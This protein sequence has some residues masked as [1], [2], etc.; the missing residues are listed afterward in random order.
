VLCTENFF[1]CCQFS[2]TCEMEI[3]QSVKPHLY[4][5]FSP[6]VSACFLDRMTWM[7]Q[8]EV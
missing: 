8:R 5:S 4:R 6:I 7:T 1:V 2:G 3:L